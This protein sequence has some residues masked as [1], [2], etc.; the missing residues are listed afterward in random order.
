MPRPIS[1]IVIHCSASPNGTS[2]FRA[3]AQGQKQTPVE[4]IDEWHAA[5]GWQRG[6]E[7]RARFNPNLAAIGY[8]Y[9]LYT[10]GAVAIGRHE[11]E[12]G[13]HVAGL[14]E[15]SLGVC[16]IG[17]DHFTIAQWSSLTHL[18]SDLQRR[19]PAARIVGHRDLSPD[20]NGDGVVDRSEWLKTCPG[21]DAPA[22]V[23]RGMISDPEHTL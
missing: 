14:N 21:F 2:L 3:T 1:L 22:W 17:T 13:A 5:R 11:D 18:V 9:V 20:K 4:V 19:F 16:L 23:R 12:I 8:H 15:R 6:R 10:N 7:A